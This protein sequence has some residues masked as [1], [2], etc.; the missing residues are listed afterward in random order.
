MFVNILTK[1]STCATISGPWCQVSLL[2]YEKAAPSFRHT[3]KH[4]TSDT[5]Q[6]VKRRIAVTYWVL[7]ISFIVVI[8]LYVV[9]LSHLFVDIHVP[10]HLCS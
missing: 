6:S 2:Q 7:C 10:F 5:R 4:V 3:E 9:C 8:V 1:C